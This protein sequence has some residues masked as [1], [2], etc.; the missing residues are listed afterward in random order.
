MI[1]YQWQRRLHAPCWWTTWTGT[2][3]CTVVHHMML[4]M[5][6]Y[7][8]APLHA[9]CWSSTVCWDICMRCADD[10]RGPGHLHALWSTICWDICQHCMQISQHMTVLV[11][12]HLLG[13]LHALCWWSIL[14]CDICMHCAGDLPC[15]ETSDNLPGG[16]SAR[17]VLMIYR[18]LGHLH[19]L[20]W[21][22]TIYLVTC[23]NCD[24]PFGP[25]LCTER[26]KYSNM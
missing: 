5:M 14:F 8:L 10:P 22:S 19:A 26:F 2:S 1:I 12:S 11:I 6:I 3:A 16:T 23:M 15:A 25:R 24:G 9:L 7:Q 13:Y 18:V 20:C 17:T 4:L 21:W